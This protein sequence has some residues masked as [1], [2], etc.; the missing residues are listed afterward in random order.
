M[1]APWLMAFSFWTRDGT[2]LSY[3]ELPVAGTYIGREYWADPANL[4][5]YPIEAGE[6]IIQEEF[7]KGKLVQR[8]VLIKPQRGPDDEALIFEAES[9]TW[10]SHRP[11]ELLYKSIAHETVFQETNLQRTLVGR[12]RV[13][14]QIRG[15]GN[16]G[17]LG[18][19]ETALSGDFSHNSADFRP[20]MEDVGSRAIN[21]LGLF[22]GVG[23]NL[24]VGAAFDGL[25]EQVGID[26]VDAWADSP[27]HYQNMVSENWDYDVDEGTMG[28]LSVAYVD[29]SVDRRTED[30][31]LPP[32][33]DDPVS[34]GIWA[35]A[36]YSKD[37]WV[38]TWDHYAETDY[39]LVAWV[40][41][42]T[43]ID[44]A[45]LY[46]GIEKTA[47]YVGFRNIGYPLPNAYRETDIVRVLCASVYRKVIDNEGTDDDV[48]ELWFR[49]A[50]WLQPF[51][52]TQTFNER[53]GRPSLKIWTAPVGLCEPT[54][55]DGDVVYRPRAEGQIEWVVEAEED[56]AAIE[57]G[58][59]FTVLGPAFATGAVSRDGAE[60]CITVQKYKLEQQTF[61]GIIQK[62]VEDLHQTADKAVVSLL[63]MR[64]PADGGFTLVDQDPL[65]VTVVA[66]NI[67]S[68]V[69]QT[70]N[71]YSRQLKQ[72]IDYYPYYTDQNEL[73]FVRY[74][75]DEYQHQ[76]NLSYTWR[77][78]KLIFESGKEVLLDYQWLKG[79]TT[80]T[81]LDM[82][83]SNQA[84]PNNIDENEP[85]TSI[86]LHMDPLTEDVV[87][88][89][90]Y[91]R[92]S[93]TARYNEATSPPSVYAAA[94]ITGR[95]TLE[96]D[97]GPQNARIRRTL[98]DREV[99]PQTLRWDEPPEVHTDTPLED[100]RP[101]WFGAGP[102][103]VREDTSSVG[104][105]APAA[106][107]DEQVNDQQVVFEQIA[108][109]AAETNI[110]LSYS[111]LIYCY[112][113]PWSEGFDGE[114]VPDS[115]YF[116]YYRS[117]PA[118]SF[119]QWPEGDYSTISQTYANNI[120]KIEDPDF[121]R[122][123]PKY[124]RPHVA[125]YTASCWHPLPR[126][127]KWPTS[128]PRGEPMIAGEAAQDSR[129]QIN[130]VAPQVANNPGHHAV[131]LVRYKDQIM[132]RIRQEYLPEWRYQYFAEQT[133]TPMSFFHELTSSAPWVPFY[134][135]AADIVPASEGYP[136]ARVAIDPDDA[137]K[138]VVIWSTLDLDGLA[139]M[140][141]VNGI[142]PFG[143]IV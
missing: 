12:D 93:P 29:G 27:H 62:N 19:S 2:P 33:P 129:F 35:Q 118:M 84:F 42:G 9:D 34:G 1:A 87:L 39:G 127:S 40:G 73:R 95:S 105:L 79:W 101:I 65:D 60:F 58:G 49:V 71:L 32:F 14:R 112:Y 36:F 113:A 7:E 124:P 11:Q 88:A 119:P 41:S 23:E 69:T 91:S 111:G 18:V 115:I 86:I 53:Y 134:A 13:V 82:I 56:F 74:S 107:V 28:A 6:Y 50:V 137:D 25:T 85:F 48:T 22:R 75:I 45:P 132:L 133:A 52:P 90:A 140:T 100:S 108:D 66:Q 80:R 47:I 139:E 70:R 44:N 96:L 122:N 103:I 102:H 89:R 17:A 77:E 3:G 59:G 38:P 4:R 43:P 120:S 81:R 116:N 10:Y 131:K 136:A 31:P 83:E 61:T 64:K 54:N 51:D 72:T 99:F 143:R 135:D 46:A 16:M 55:V 125:D 76:Q 30:L 67:N 121:V 57:A 130:N 26:L 117:Q 110:R 20:G 15:D 37:R 106:F 138:R 128:D 5:Q 114:I 92:V 104:Y 126:T 21:A 109:I 94:E 141:D 123:K 63:F 97:L 8:A 24:A 68:T 78:R 142:D 98:L